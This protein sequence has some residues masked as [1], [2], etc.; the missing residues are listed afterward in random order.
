MEEAV[1]REALQDRFEL[2]QKAAEELVAYAAEQRKGSVDLFQFTRLIN[3][4]FSAEEKLLLIEQLWRVVYADGV[5][6]QY[7]D[8]LVGKLAGLLH[9]PHREL[10]DIKL[11]VREE[12][13]AKR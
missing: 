7:E 11:G 6:H 5:L 9:L 12:L 13:K 10:I 1:I 3:Q 8:A 2:S 4:S